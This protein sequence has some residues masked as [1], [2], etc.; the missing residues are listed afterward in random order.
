MNENLSNTYVL[1]LVMVWHSKFQFSFLDSTC[2]FIRPRNPLSVVIL[3]QV[4]PKRKGSGVGLRQSSISSYF[5]SPSSNMQP[6]HQMPP[7]MQQQM[8]MPLYPPMMMQQPMMHQQMM[9][10]PM[11]CNPQMMQHLQ[12]P[13]YFPNPMV[14]QV[15]DPT[16]QGLAMVPVGRS[17]EREISY[18]VPP[19]TPFSDDA[20]KLST[21]Y[22][23]LG[24]AWKYG[25]AR[26]ATKKFRAT[27]CAAC[28]CSE[29]PMLK[30]SSMED[31][32]VDLLLFC[33]AG[34]LPSVKVC[35]LGADTKGEA[36]LA[37]RMQ[38]MNKLRRNRSRLDALAEEFDNL[39]AIALR[40]GYPP[41]LFSPQLRQMY[42]SS[43]GR[44]TAQRRIS[45]PA[46]IDDAVGARVNSSALALRN[47]EVEEADAD[48]NRVGVPA[49]ATDD[50]TSVFAIELAASPKSVTPPVQL[51]LPSL[52]LPM[53]SGSR[54][55]VAATMHESGAAKVGRKGGASKG[56]VAVA[57]GSVEV[58]SNA[59]ALTQ[60]GPAALSSPSEV[61]QS[62]LVGSST[63]A[64]ST[65]DVRLAMAAVLN[66]L[67]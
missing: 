44:M 9:Q 55:R 39:P 28:N 26:V 11:M 18:G 52:K 15:P 62:G 64:S 65:T 6:A 48:D 61:V 32:W 50:D 42:E 41:E 7:Q 3:P 34:V 58:Q 49:E 66:Q 37:V 43:R 63:S 53:G 67:G 45:M 13:Q 4:M 51:S 36:R 23:A 57:A 59:I 56:E 12:M 29:Y 60:F 46:A 35:D 1:E 2:C 16:Q 5:L 8:Q 14:A 38:Y 40:C 27:L 30:T 10:H 21:A 33:I 24:M 19:Y 47:G 17:L 25:T 54:K 22:K 20:K 31:E